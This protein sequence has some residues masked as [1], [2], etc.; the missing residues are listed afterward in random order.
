MCGGGKKRR[1]AATM[2]KVVAGR[3]LIENPADNYV[4][5]LVV[6]EKGQQWT[7]DTTA[8]GITVKTAANLTIAA[9]VRNTTMRPETFRKRFF[10]PNRVPIKGFEL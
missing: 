8:V 7:T 1:K 5:M 6:N 9:L 3:C 10:K 4:Q 2:S